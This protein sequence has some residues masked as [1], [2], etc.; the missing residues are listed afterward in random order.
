[1]SEP[2][3]FLTVFHQAGPDPRIVKGADGSRDYFTKDELR[4]ACWSLMQS[5]VPEVG[6]FHADGTVGHGQIV[7][8]FLWPDG[9]PDWHVVAADGS[10]VVIKEGDWLGRILPDEVAWNLYKAGHIGGVSIQ[11]QARRRRITRRDS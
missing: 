8:S 9:A 3:Y 4:K 6:L 2:H 11:G 5:G 10:E 1:L 7:E